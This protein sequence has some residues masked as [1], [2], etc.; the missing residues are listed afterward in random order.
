MKKNWQNIKNILNRSKPKSKFPEYFIINGT[1]EKQPSIIA[2]EFNKYF[3]SIG[4]ELAERIPN[5]PGNN[6]KTHLLQVHCSSKFHFE[7]CTVESTIKIINSLKPK[8]SAGPDGISTKLL[9]RICSII[10]PSLTLVINQSLFTGVFPDLFKIAKV[11]P[12]FKKGDARI[13]GNYRP[14]SVLSSFSK[15][16]EKKNCF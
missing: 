6:F 11:I 1:L 7:L 16:F 13:F 2:N 4:P 15:V 12:L 3:T 8:S 14:I 9:K 5:P 10:A